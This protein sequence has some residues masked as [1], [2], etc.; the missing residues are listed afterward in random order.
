MKRRGKTFLLFSII[1]LLATSAYATVYLNDTWVDGTRT[2]Q[3][4]PAESAWFSSNGS[5][6]TAATGSMDLALGANAVM[7]I[8]YFT[9]ND[10]SPVQLNVGDTLNATFKM[11]F[12]NVAPANT[13]LGF[14]IALADFADS[15]LSPRRVSADGF[16][17]SSQGSGVQSYA[18][19][20]NMG[21]TFNLAGAMSLRKRTTLSDNSLLGTTG[22]WTTIGAGP[23]S[24]NNFPGF[25]AGVQ[26]NLQLSLQRTGAN[27]MLVSAS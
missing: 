15:A 26:Y 27:S 3:N 24:S 1:L 25:T 13:S 8:T 22:D 17:S 5:A 16:S 11:R 20:Q 6:L 18:L 2:N 10:T 7:G 12:T 23:I 19:F 21:T 14:R 4:L 9:T